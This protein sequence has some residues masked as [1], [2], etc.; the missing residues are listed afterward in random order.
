[1][2]NVRLKGKERKKNGKYKTS[3]YSPFGNSFI[4]YF[5]I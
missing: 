5:F 1:M 4:Y 3:N 2:E